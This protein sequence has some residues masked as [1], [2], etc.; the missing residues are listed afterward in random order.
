MDLL[1]LANA[2][3]PYLNTSNVILQFFY[4]VS[5]TLAFNNL[6]TSNVILQYTSPYAFWINIL[7]LNTSNVILQLEKRI[8]K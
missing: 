5:V 8:H 2:I 1:P 6:N 4:C 7:Y 3:L